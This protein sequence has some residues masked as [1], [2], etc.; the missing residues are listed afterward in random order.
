[1]WVIKLLKK[2]AGVFN[3]I[4]AKVQM[5][6]I[7]IAGPHTRCFVWRVTAIGSQ[8]EIRLGAEYSRSRRCS[9]FDRRARGARANHVKSK[10]RGGDDQIEWRG[11][12]ITGENRGIFRH[13]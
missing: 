7:L 8:R 9:G 10:S 4:D 11:G 2:L 6:D 3:P 5:V 1:M 13:R 12:Q